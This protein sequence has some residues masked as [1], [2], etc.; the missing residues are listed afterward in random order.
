[1]PA[2]VPTRAVPLSR[3]PPLRGPF[4]C[5]WG[6]TFDRSRHE[7]GTEVKA[8]TY[9]AMSIRE[10]EGDAEVFVIVDICMPVSIGWLMATSASYGR[11]TAGAARGAAAFTQVQQTVWHGWQRIIVSTR[12]LGP[13]SVQVCAAAARTEGGCTSTYQ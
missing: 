7:V 6:E 11:A 3:S 2:P 13:Q 12:S 8:I 4:N 9:S 10:T 5:S 1:M